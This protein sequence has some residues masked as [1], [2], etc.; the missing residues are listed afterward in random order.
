MRTHRFIWSRN[1][2]GTILPSNYDP[3]KRPR[4]QDW[5]GELVEN[6]A[7]YMIKREDIDFT[8]GMRISGTVI[9]HVMDDKNSIEIDTELD[10]MICNCIAEN[11]G[12]HQ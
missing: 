7:F 10:L 3:Q 11:D 12:I 8:T 5:D 6:G 9:P 2:D 4:R 1:T